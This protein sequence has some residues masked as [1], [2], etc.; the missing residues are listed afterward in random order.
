MEIIKSWIVNGHQLLVQIENGGYR[1]GNTMDR[2][3]LGYISIRDAEKL[4]EISKNKSTLPDADVKYLLETA[5]P[6]K[7][8]NSRQRAG[9]G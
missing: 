3:G 8:Q 9:G 5:Q 1:I 4:I 2:Y 6:V 7:L